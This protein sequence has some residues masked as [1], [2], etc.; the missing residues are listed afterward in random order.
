[1]GGKGISL[2][3]VQL[4]SLIRNPEFQAATAKMQSANA[5]A[6]SADCH[7][8]NVML[9]Y[10]LVNE[11]S[12]NKN[13][14]NKDKVVFIGLRAIDNDVS[15]GEKVVPCASQNGFRQHFI[16]LP[17]VIDESMKKNI[18][19]LSK[20][21]VNF[22]GNDLLTMSEQNAMWSRI[23]F[24]KKCITEGHIK[25]IP[26]TEWGKKE[27]HQWIAKEAIS[28]INAERVPSHEG[29]QA[30]DFLPE[31][32]PGIYSFINWCYDGNAKQFFIPSKLY[33][34]DR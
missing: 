24:F 3:D 11:P 5:I 26:N 31:N 27:A 4:K 9:E 28:A 2:T 34:F 20:K 18:M 33:K 16:G 12:N 32:D 8:G 30:M 15:F 7:L 29:K 25:V 21:D 22:I 6:G 13:L 19:D 17:S 14:S 23:E 10:Q 1:L